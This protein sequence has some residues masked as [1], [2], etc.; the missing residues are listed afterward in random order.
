M[1]YV[2]GRGSLFAIFAA[3]FFWWLDATYGASP[4]A[5]VRA[6]W[7]LA[8]TQTPP[9]AARWNDEPDG[10]AVLKASFK[11]ALTSGSTIEDLYA[12]AFRGLVPLANAAV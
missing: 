10:F 5:L 12:D 8:P 9:G 1:H 6:M 3:L 2:L 4:G 7:A 11:D